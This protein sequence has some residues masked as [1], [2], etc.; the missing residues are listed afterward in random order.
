MTGR[1]LDVEDSSAT[2]PAA[3][4]QSV[5]LA[6]LRAADARIARSSG[7]P[8][9]PR[10][11]R[12]V[13]LPGSDP[14]A[15]VEHRVDHLAASFG[16]AMQAHARFRTWVSTAIED[17]QARLARDDEDGGGSG[18]AASQAD[19]DALA[20]RLDDFDAQAARMVTYLTHLGDDLQ[21]RMDRLEAAVQSGT[22]PAAPAADPAVH[23][24]SMVLPPSHPHH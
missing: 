22:R 2:D 17:L 21:H 12:P 7:P 3:P 18:D 5:M 6:A 14:F 4:D 19:L 20:A 10:P 15:E 11:P 24:R 9:A 8:A 16:E 13:A 23:L 1:S